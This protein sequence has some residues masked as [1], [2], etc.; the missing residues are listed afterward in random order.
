MST[1]VIGLGPMGR[2]MVHR[3][4]AAGHRVTVW[5]RTPGRA[6][7]LVAVG[8]VRA[9]TPAEAVA[10]SRLAILS[11]TDYAAM[12]DVLG[13]AGD[14]LAGRVVANLSS[15]TPQAS[16]DAAAWLADRGAELVV[17][18]VMVPPEMVG[19]AAAYVFYS[20]PRSVFEAHEPTLRVIGR[21]DYRGEDPAL[22]QL[23][24]Q[25]QLTVFLTAGA[26]FMQAAALVGTA[27]V[28]AEELA[29]LTAETLALLSGSLPGTAR[30]I[31]EGD[32]SGDSGRAEM[33]SASA[34][35]VVGAAEAAGL[36]TTRPAAVRSLYSRLVA[37]GHGKG[38]PTRIVEVIRNRL[39]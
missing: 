8:A 20:G 34:D 32:H 27:G 26:A 35:H 14:A 2:A 13:D 1:T 37:A 6:D 39:D 7:D 16:R 12:Y 15:D 4:L 10:A 23:F 22:A 30:A 31:D 36:D 9:G 11:L 24:Y 38:A 33:R 3:L 29:P 25:A 18:G 17:G 5:N 19:T 28:S 21:P